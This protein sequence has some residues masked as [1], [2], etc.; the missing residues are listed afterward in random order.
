[1]FLID[2]HYMVRTD[3]RDATVSQE[4]TYIIKLLLGKEI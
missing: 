4:N 1:M 3:S 2:K